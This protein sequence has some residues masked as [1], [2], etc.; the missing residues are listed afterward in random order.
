MYKDIEFC[1]LDFSMVTEFMWMLSLEMGPTVTSQ[2][3]TLCLSTRLGCLRMFME[4]LG[5]QLLFSPSSGSL[6]PALLHDMA[7]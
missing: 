5:P 3:T 2:R 7:S 1:Q 4:P 6:A